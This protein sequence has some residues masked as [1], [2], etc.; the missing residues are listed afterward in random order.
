MTV[1]YGTVREFSVK[2]GFGF[3]EADKQV[4]PSKLE[5]APTDAKLGAGIFVHSTGINSTSTMVPSLEPG[6][7]VKFS[8]KWTEKGVQAVD[9]MREDGGEVRPTTLHRV[10]LNGVCA[11]L[12]SSWNE[13]KG[14]GWI[15][16]DI[17]KEALRSQRVPERAVDLN[18]MKAYVSRSDLGHNLHELAENLPVIFNLY[19]DEKGLGATNIAIGHGVPLDGDHLK[20]RLA[21]ADK[22]LGHV[23][24]ASAGDRPKALTVLDTSVQN[25]QLKLVI[26]RSQVGSV[27]GL[28]GQSIKKL[29]EESGAARVHVDDMKQFGVEGSQ[30]GRAR[31]VGIHGDFASIAKALNLLT[32]AMATDPEDNPG[33]EEGEE[34]GQPAPRRE[35]ANWVVKLMVPYV[36]LDWVVGDDGA[37]LKKLGERTGTKLCTEFS[38]DI[39]ALGQVNCVVARGAT[40]NVAEREECLDILSSRIAFAVGWIL[41][42]RVHNLFPAPRKPAVTA[43]QWQGGYGGWN[44]S[45]NTGWN[46][47]WSG[48]DSSWKQPWPAPATGKGGG[49][50]GGK[51]GKGKGAQKGSSKG[52]SASKGAAKPEAPRPAPAAGK[53]VWKVKEG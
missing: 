18:S 27:I 46:Q 53:K 12:V 48:G 42:P 51:D 24:S 21:S 26:P 15:T 35:R 37:F 40:A 47:G 28:K 36:L 3:L 43:G 38:Q 44:S 7:R 17:T 25:A 14:F 39:P 9:V 49:K 33:T 30:Q 34:P 11:G 45:Y 52:A 6:E 22:A 23:E 8:L 19:W 5:G 16:C 2:S 4:D 50:D 10:Q 1:F 13:K 29:L 41:S 32:V 20:H 31:A